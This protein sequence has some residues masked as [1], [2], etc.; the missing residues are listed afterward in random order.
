[1]QNSNNYR[2][3]MEETEIDLIDLAKELLRHWKSIILCAL[4]F[5]VLGAAYSVHKGDTADSTLDTETAAAEELSP[6]ELE[7]EIKSDYELLVQQYNDD[8]RFYN[9]KP[10]VI[11]EYSTAVSMLSKEIERLQTID[12]SDEEAMTQCLIKISSLQ[13]AVNN[14]Q[15]MRSNY[16]KLEKPVKPLGFE[17][18]RKEAINAAEE[19]EIQSS[20]GMRA[21]LKYA[22]LGLFA[23]GFLGCFGWSVVYVFDGK[24]KLASDVERLG[25]NVLGSIDNMG[26]VAANVRNYIPEDVKSVLVTGTMP[27]ATLKNV[28]DAVAAITGVK[29][30][31]VSGKLN[32]NADTAV[33]L[34]DVDAV[35]LVEKVKVTKRSDIR[36]ELSMIENAGKTLIGV[37]V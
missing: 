2:G 29:D 17:E 4:I 14:A 34:S 10:D 12:E 26:L 27:D 16:A 3:N 11:N 23:G 5:T 9:M 7:A 6:E 33:M 15:S 20:G 1:M 35:V 32:Q 8:V 13:S 21:I 24:L 37:S 22:L 18:Y 25:V 36:E 19:E 28:A 31:K 30:I